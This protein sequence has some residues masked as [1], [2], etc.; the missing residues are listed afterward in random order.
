MFP[1]EDGDIVATAMLVYWRVHISCM[2]NLP[3]EVLFSSSKFNDS[4][5]TKCNLEFRR[6][7][8]E[9]RVV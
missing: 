7:S 5:E 8:Q 2:E 1:I 9:A 3:P 6:S 4:K